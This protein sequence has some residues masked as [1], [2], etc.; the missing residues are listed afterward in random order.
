MRSAVHLAF[1]SSEV[2]TPEARPYLVELAIFIAS[3]SSSKSN[4]YVTGP[5]IS[6][7]AIVASTLTLSKIVGW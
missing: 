4:T 6:S 1:W 3:S 5:K 2:N 7:W